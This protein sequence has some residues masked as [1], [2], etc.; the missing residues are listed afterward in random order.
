MSTN[1]YSALKAPE[2]IQALMRLQPDEAEILGIV[3]D[4]ADPNATLDGVPLISKMIM[5]ERTSLVRIL[6]K[7]GANVNVAAIDVGGLQSRPLNLACSNASPDIVKV[8][9]DAGADVNLVD[10]YGRTPMMWAINILEHMNG[11]DV[12]LAIPFEARMAV[13]DHLLNAGAD[14]NKMDM[15]GASALHMACSFS[16]EA[17]QGTQ[18]FGATYDGA[19]E[20]VKFLLDRGADVNLRDPKSLYNSTPLCRAASYD[21]RDGNRVEIF[22]VLIEHGA[23]WDI[24]DSDGSYP[25]DLVND[26]VLGMPQSMAYG[27][28]SAVIA[29]DRLKRQAAAYITPK[30]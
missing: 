10:R 7:A 4:G 27:F 8:L 13:I 15:H 28:L 14:I 22:R 20:L 3:K 23:R 25:L 6:A 1:Y 9:V 11:P 21:N 16:V 30:P 17:G 12:A 29:R 19:P 26:E 24:P 5:D 2:L 18:G